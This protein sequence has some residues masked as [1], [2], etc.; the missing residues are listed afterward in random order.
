[1]DELRICYGAG[2]RL[3]LPTAGR[4]HTCAL[5]DHVKSMHLRVRLALQGTAAPQPC[6]ARASML[7]ALLAVLQPTQPAPPPAGGYV[8]MPGAN[9]QAN[10]ILSFEYKGGWRD[11]KGAVV[12]TVLT[13]LLGGG[14]SFSSGGP[15]KGMHSRLYTRVLNQHHWVHSC[16]AFSSTF[17]SSGEGRQAA[18]AG[19]GRLGYAVAAAH[20][21][22]CSLHELAVCE[23][24]RM[25]RRTQLL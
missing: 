3:C 10:L 14:S 8:H 7:H 2:Q 16:S 22:R 13:F 11:V 25:H 15:G 20:M 21:N 5:A 17:N 23:Q 19:A 1:M 4:T 12:M 9:P 24:Q 18:S 6:H